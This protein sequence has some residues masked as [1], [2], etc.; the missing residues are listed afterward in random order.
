MNKLRKIEIE[1][2][3]TLIYYVLFFTAG[4]YLTIKGY[5]ALVIIGMLLLECLDSMNKKLGEISN[6]LKSL[7]KEHESEGGRG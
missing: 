2:Y 1:M 3:L 7:L 6:K 4:A 5:F